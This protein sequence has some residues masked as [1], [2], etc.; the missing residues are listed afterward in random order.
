MG[1]IRLS[2]WWE[3]S[4]EFLFITF[5]RVSF[6]HRLFVF[7]FST[8]TWTQT[9]TLMAH[10]ELFMSSDVFRNPSVTRLGALIRTKV[11]SAS[12]KLVVETQM[13]RKTSADFLLLKRPDCASLSRS[14]WSVL[15]ECFLESLAANCKTQ[16]FKIAALKSLIQRDFGR[17]R[18]S[19]FMRI[20]FANDSR[21]WRSA[22]LRSVN[23]A[24]MS[25]I[26]ATVGSIFST[27]SKIRCCLEPDSMS[28]NVG[29]RSS[30]DRQPGGS[31]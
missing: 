5:F 12:Q 3:L 6:F 30:P 28:N 16:N 24:R 14:A 27:L 23:D 11:V 19:D 17:I 1:F 10:Y 7:N 31:S 13:T 9:P 21:S 26:I 15:S 29:L 18:C 22:W 25:H 2:G 4:M 8:F 20:A